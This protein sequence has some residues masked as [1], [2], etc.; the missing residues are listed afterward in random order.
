M[1]DIQDRE[2][3]LRTN[4]AEFSA[5]QDQLRS[6]PT[7]LFVELTENCNL[8]CRMCRSATPYRP[9]RDMSEA[10]FEVIAA[11]LFRS[12]TLI[13]L[14]GWGESTML[15][16]FGARLSRATESGARVR[17]V[18]NAIAL[19]ATLWEQLM[20]ADAIVVVSV[21]AAT[22]ATSAALN[23]GPFDRVMRSLETG[24]QI[25]ERVGKGSI[26][27][28]TVLSSLNLH[29]L[30]A[31]VA[32]AARMHVK[33]VTAFPVVADSQ[34]PL[35]LGWVRSAL[36]ALLSS[37]FQIAAVEGVELRL[38]ASPLDELTEAGCLPD[39]CSH[40]W[41][42]CYINYAGFVGYC[43]HL[44]GHRSLTLGHLT[45]DGFDAIWNGGAF[46]ALR[47]AHVTASRNS[48]VSGFEHCDWCYRRRYVDFEDDLDPRA[49]QRVCRSMGTVNAGGG[50]DSGNFLANTRITESSRGADDRSHHVVLHRS[51]AQL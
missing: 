47:L 25:R 41:S 39:R 44:I 13:D 42:F 38:G 17:V 2:E 37:A 28:N 8:S 32:M 51:S 15:P 34:D 5:G 6:R 10:I 27:I 50:C 16:E 36:P 4:Q 9:E 43:D 22:S 7:A 18:T 26:R 11:E 3:N 14:R 33:R 40:P 46:R 1:R 30:P 19:T 45:R 21:D 48:S 12:A 23:R 24:T 35:D 29:E 20:A 31:I 49:E